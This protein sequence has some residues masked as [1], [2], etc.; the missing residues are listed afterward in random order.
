[1]TEQKKGAQTA[2][3]VQSARES[4]HNQFTPNSGKTQAFHLISN[5]NPQCGNIQMFKSCFYE[6]LETMDQVDRAGIAAGRNNQ[7]LRIVMNTFCLFEYLV[8]PEVR[9]F[10]LGVLNQREKESE[11]NV[12]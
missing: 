12:Q 3:T 8:K 1:M 10:V 6:L 4:P 7:S 5:P 11:N 9:G 2:A